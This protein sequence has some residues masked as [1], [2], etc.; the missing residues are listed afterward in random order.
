M[1]A[2]TRNAKDVIRDSIPSIAAS[3]ERNLS[4]SSH[5]IRETS[6]RI[7][8][9][10]TNI[11]GRSDHDLIEAM[12][13]IETAPRTVENIRSTS[14]AMRKLPAL[15]SSEQDEML[16]AFCF[17]LLTINFAPLWND[18]CAVLKL[19]S[20]RSGAKIWERAFA[21]LTSEGIEDKEDEFKGSEPEDAKSESPLDKVWNESQLNYDTRLWHLYDMVFLPIS[22]ALINR[23]CL[24]IPLML[25][26]ILGP[27]RF[28]L[29]SKSLSWRSN[30]R[31]TSS[32]SSSHSNP[33]PPKLPA[34]TGLDRIESPF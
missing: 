20:E 1:L 25:I 10:I 11:T 17:G 19:I 15:S 8:L 6:L 3:L 32:P 18:A 23:H 28:V 12:L 2:N 29:S 13:N 7:L 5:A 22:L 4:R 14:L 34:N 27:N 30:I 31:V 33:P 9:S 21:Q 24:R 26:Q 16:I